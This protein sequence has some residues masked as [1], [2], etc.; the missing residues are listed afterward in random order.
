MAELTVELLLKR[1]QS[2][3]PEERTAAWQEAGSLGAAAIEPLVR[4]VLECEAQ[5]ASLKAEG[6][7]KELAQPLEVGRAAKRALWKIVRTV[8]APNTAAE[9][10]EA[11]EEALLNYIRPGLP[12]QLRRDVLW[13]LSEIGT[14]QTVRAIVDLPNVLEDKGIRDDARACVQRIGTPYA[15]EALQLGLREAK[16]DFRLAIAESLRVLGVAV[17]P[18]AYPSR[19]L[20]PKPEPTRDRTG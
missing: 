17:D 12:D 16:D 20:V 3:S 15:I 6:K 8:G 2:E 14:D 10:K 9:A 1:L 11:V 4:L 5:V 18:E 19:K 13:M 7:T